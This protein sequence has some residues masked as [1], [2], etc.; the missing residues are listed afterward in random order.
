MQQVVNTAGCNSVGMP[1]RIV[2]KGGEKK[3]CPF[4]LKYRIY[5]A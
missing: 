1:G 4:Q 2:L 5:M 3:D